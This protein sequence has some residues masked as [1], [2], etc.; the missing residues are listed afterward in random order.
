M[1]SVP[2]CDWL[3]PVDGVL[4][5]WSIVVHGQACTASQSGLLSVHL[6]MSCL[7]LTKHPNILYRPCTDTQ[8]LGST[9]FNHAKIASSA[10]ELSVDTLELLVY[11]HLYLV[12]SGQNDERTVQTTR[13]AVGVAQKGGW[14]DEAS[15]TWNDLDAHGKKRAR[16]VC[17]ALLF[18]CR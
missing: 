10:P 13:Q 3:C 4:G 11:I 12:L 1:I 14:L 6:A 2:Q 18:A 17:D 8:A 5:V 9:L 15:A 16:R 7:L